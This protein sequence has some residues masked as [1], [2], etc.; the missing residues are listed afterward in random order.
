MKNSRE[1]VYTTF[2]AEYAPAIP[3]SYFHVARLSGL[4]SQDECKKPFQ[5]ANICAVG[6]RAFGQCFEQCPVGKSQLFFLLFI[7]AG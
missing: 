6:C 7:S 1:K 2:L 4:L 3:L 5:Q